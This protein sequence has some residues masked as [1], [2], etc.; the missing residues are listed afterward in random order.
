[1]VDVFETIDR[2]LAIVSTGSLENTVMSP[3]RKTVPPTQKHSRSSS[4]G[5]KGLIAKEETEKQSAK[6]KTVLDNRFHRTVA[7]Q[8][9]LPIQA[10]D[11]WI[12]ADRRMRS[13]VVVE[14]HVRREPAFALR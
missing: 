6:T 11:W 3:R 2:T 7:S 4:P 1:V 13:V 8:D 9:V 10:T 12:I 5:R 14:M